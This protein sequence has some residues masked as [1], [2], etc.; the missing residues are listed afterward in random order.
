MKTTINKIYLYFYG[1]AAQGLRQSRTPAVFNFWHVL[2]I[3][4]HAVSSCSHIQFIP[5]RSYKMWAKY[6]KLDWCERS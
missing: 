3:K 4:M 6:R 1:F 5:F 2:E